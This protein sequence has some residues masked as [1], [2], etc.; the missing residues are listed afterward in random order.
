MITLYRKYRPQVIDDL[1]ISEVRDSLSRLLKSG[2][3]PQALLFS[4]PKGTGKTSAARIVAKILNC[5]DEKN[6][7]CNKCDQCKSINNGNNIDVIEI[8]AASYTGVDNIREIRDAV[9][10]S[11]ARAKRKVYIID[12]A[13]MLS[14]GASNALLKTLEE[15]PEHVT[16]IL[17]TTNPEKLIATIRSRTTNVN[18]RKANDDEIARSLTR[19]AEGEKIKIPEATLHIIAKYAKGS[20]RDAVKVVEQMMSEGRKFDAVETEEYLF[21]SKSLGVETL[22][23]CLAEKDIKGALSEIKNAIDSG[24]RAIDLAEELLSRLRKDM[25]SVVGMGD[26]TTSV[27]KEDLINLVD[28]LSDYTA[29]IKTSIIEE[30]PI[31]LAIIR[32]CS[33]GRNIVEIETKESTVVEKTTISL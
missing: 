6:K 7:P 2:K 13:H 21:K 11:P 26:V 10:L 16:F 29:K 15:P 5:E 23:N 20:F 24:V 1:D 33:N 4:G 28:L 17:A 18:F 19:V 32:W 9:K 27:P 22:V 12:E 14:T 8:D 3:F 31:E 25:L 30:L